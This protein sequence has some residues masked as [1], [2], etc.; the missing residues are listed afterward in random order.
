MENSK[1]TRQ[2]LIDATRDMIDRDGV[3]AVSMRELGR[4]MGLSRT[5]VYRHFTSKEDLLA[6]V[7]TGDFLTLVDDLGAHSPGHAD[8]Q[9]RVRE[10]LQ[11]FYQFAM[12]SNERFTLMF[13]RPWNREGYPQLH[14]SAQALF[15]LI[16]SAVQQVHGQGPS[17]GSS[18][19]QVTAM[20]AAF[21]TGLVQLNRAGHLEPE[22]GLDDPA[23]LID[24]FLE[25][26][27]ARAGAGP[28][29]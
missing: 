26:L 15:A 7:A 11:H 28:D 13:I 25:A 27:T 6:A 17:I 1:N 9:R 22:K 24:A 29:S 2:R 16:Y 18:P 3:D 10:I 23:G 19:R 14:E 21:V 12:A 5:A 20:C 8:P 4:A